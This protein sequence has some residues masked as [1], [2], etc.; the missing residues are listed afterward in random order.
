MKYIAIRKKME[1]CGEIKELKVL[2]YI[3]DEQWVAHSLEMDLL[4]YGKD[5]DH[6]LEELKEV[7]EAHCEYAEDNNRKDSI[8]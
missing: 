8:Y 4:G 2:G 5:F 6:A 1:I 3:E 7:I